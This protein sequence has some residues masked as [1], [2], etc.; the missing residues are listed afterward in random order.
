[1]SGM[2]GKYHTEK[3]KKKISQTLKGRIPWNKGK[4]HTEDTKERMKL[5]SKH[6]G[7][8]SGK[9]NTFYGKKHTT[10]SKKKISETKIRLGIHRGDK[11]PFYS[12][13]LSLE[14]RKKISEMRKTKI[15]EK[16]SNWKGG[17]V[18]FVCE[19]CG[20]EKDISSSAFK[21]GRGKTCSRRCRGI[22]TTKHMKTKDT[23]IEIAIEK[24]LI[25]RHIPYMKQV[26]I[27]GIALVD[28]L[29]PSKVIIQCDGDYW[30]SEKINKGKDMAQDMA[31]CVYGYKIFRFTETEIKKSPSGCIDKIING[32]F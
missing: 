13:H 32:V 18:K 3:T 27:L 6:N 22:Y 11:N 12:K 8:R 2:S 31:L 9:L 1:M 10:E 14:T 29:L 16:N 26:S 7:G 19:I 15:G 25:E 23:S 24:E 30:H 5:V 28:F 4:C 17:K 21:R 20:K